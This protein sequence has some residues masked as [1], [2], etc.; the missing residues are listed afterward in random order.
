MLKYSDKLFE[1]SGSLSD[2]RY[3]L[4]TLS[5]VISC[6][7]NFLC[8]FRLCRQSIDT[9]ECIGFSAAKIVFMLCTKCGP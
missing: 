6:L 7:H 3:T 9:A 8:S 5:I 1:K 4:V 2:D